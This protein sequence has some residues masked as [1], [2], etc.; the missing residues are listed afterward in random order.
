MSNSFF[1]LTDLI[2]IND[3]NA[4][5]LG[6]TDLL[7]RA[8]FLKVLN[9]TTASNGTQHHYIKQTGAPT[10]GFRAVN[11]GKDNSTS[12]YTEVD[13]TLKNLDASFMVD[14]AVANGYR[15]GPQALISRQANEALQQAFFTFEKQVF[16]G[17][18]ADANGFAGLADNTSFDGLS[19]SMVVG[20]GGTTASTGSS[21]WLIRTTPNE[22]DMTAVIGQQGQITIGETVV[23]TKADD[24]TATKTYGVYYTPIQAYAGLQIGSAYSVARIA[25]LTADSGK[26]LTDDLIF[27]AISLFPAYAQPTHIVMNRRSLAQLQKSRTA[28]NPTGA[29]APFPQDVSGIPVVVTDAISSTEA[30]LT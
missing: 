10:V 16:Y 12:A 15:G 14:L 4:R 25:N 23:A 30:L 22:M 24:S 27:Q 18:G 2:K 19:D 13:I 9:A 8:P 20:A 3:Q 29:P 5:D 6:V 21:C 7:N 28:T 1:G 11:T 17:T 26:G